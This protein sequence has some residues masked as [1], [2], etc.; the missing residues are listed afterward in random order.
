MKYLYL[1]LFSA[2]IIALLLPKCSNDNKHTFR[3]IEKIK[4][5]HDTVRIVEAQRVKV[6]TKWRTLRDSVNVYH[7]DTI[8]RDVILTCDTIIKL[9]STNIALL[10]DIIKVQ[11][12]VIDSLKKS[13][14]PYF[15]GFKHGFIAG[16]IVTGSIFTGVF[17]K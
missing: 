16:S 9:D 15:K 3:Y 5:I 7:L 1:I 10:N 17:V 14:K 11:E 4:R 13:K 6:L 8:I 12:V 2:L